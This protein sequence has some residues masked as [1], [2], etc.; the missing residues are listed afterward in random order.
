[1]NIIIGSEGFLGS[2]LCKI[3]D[4][5][6]AV[7]SKSY[8]N[9]IDTFNYNNTNILICADVK[10]NTKIITDLIKLNMNNT[11]ILFSSAAIYYN[12]NKIVYSEYDINN[13]NNDKINNYYVDTLKLNEELFSQLL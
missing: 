1:M 12:I 10:N 5:I 6:I 13:T 7:N 2:Y 11:Y 8:D 9:F 3:F 4:N